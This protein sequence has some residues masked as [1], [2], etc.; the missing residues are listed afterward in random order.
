MHRWRAATFA[1]CVAGA[2]VSPVGGAIATNACAAS[3]VHVA[4]VVDTGSG[5]SVSAVCVP[6]GASDNGAVL[7]ATRASMLGTPPPRYATSGLLCGI[8]GFPATG[9]GEPHNGHYSYW[10]Y[11]HGSGGAWTY[12][13]IGPATSRVDPG[14]V[15][16]WRWQPD[17]SG[18][19]DPPPRVAPV[20]TA[21]C[22]PAA[23]PPPAPAATTPATARGV[24]SPPP[25]T[26]PRVG[27]DPGAAQASPA[28]RSGATP[29]TSRSSTGSRTSTRPTTLRRPQRTAT[30]SSS[31][32]RGAVASTA[33][34]VALAAGGIAHA[35]HTSGSGGMPVGLVIGGVLVVALF[36]G[37][38]IAARR[39]RS[40][41]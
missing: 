35:Q 26:V 37:G 29:A 33:T 20:A 38:A 21:I 9:C 2:L 10:S 22:K 7:L 31:V 14:V 24:G 1:A 39:R 41:A 17:G 40:S 27:A 3:A 23:P 13:N 18:R 25:T 4:V 15:E 11:W 12:A 5:S 30:S 36:A 6:A 19:S 8:D 32:A 34:T 28:T 16:G